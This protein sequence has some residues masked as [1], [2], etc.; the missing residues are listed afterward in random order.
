MSDP[1]ASPRSILVIRL[2]AVGDVVRTLPAVSCLRRSFPGARIAWAVEEPSREILEGHPDIDDVVVLRRRLLVSGLKLR[3]LGGALG[4]LKSFRRTLRE[5]RI[6]WAVDFHGTLKSALIARMSGAARTYGFGPGHARERSYI[7]YSDPIRLPHGPMSRASRALALAGALGAD[8]SSPRRSLPV[9]E[10]AAASARAFLARSAPARPRAMLYPGTS[11]TQAYKRYP[12]SH[13]ARIADALAE[14][15]VGSIVIGWGPGEEGIAEDLRRR[16]TRSAVL[17]PPSRLTELAELIRSCDLFIGSD[18]GPLH[19]AAAVGVPVVALYGPTDAA[20]NAPFTDRPHLSFSGD[21]ICRP[22]RNRGC[23]NRSC[24]RLIDP[25]KVAAAAM[26]IL[27][28]E[29]SG[30]S[31]EV[32]PA[33]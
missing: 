25:D 11:E 31:P 3:G 9:R 15:S 7:L 14:R 26:E 1:T 30:V 27:R 13:F 8:T 19:I 22:C 29:R 10:E 24:L 21:V 6:D 12:V 2:G 23:Q 4:H 33:G 28:V 20:T 32:R 5:R 18:T 17:A 16:M